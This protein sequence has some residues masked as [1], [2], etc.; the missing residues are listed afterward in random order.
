[1]KNQTWSKILIICFCLA[2][3]FI[4]VAFDFAWSG[5]LEVKSDFSRFT[6]YFS[7]LKPQEYAQLNSN[8]ILIN[9]FPVYFDLYLPRD[10][11]KAEIFVIY[12]D[13]FERQIILGLNTKL[14][15][16]EKRLVDLAEKQNGYKIKTADFDLADANV[17]YGKLRFKLS[18]EG[19][20]A[21]Q[22]G[23]YLKEIRVVLTRPPI[24]QENIFTNIRKYINYVEAQY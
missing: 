10:F 8:P 5:K 7:V 12:Q 14:G 17:N 3:I 24:W 4:L 20:E 6:P 15:W 9:N 21:G 1:M 23:V 2:V 22:T 18:A 16:Q 13:E 19:F 11:G